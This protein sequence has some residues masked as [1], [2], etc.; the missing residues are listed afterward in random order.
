M[1]RIHFITLFP[2]FCAPYFATS[3]LG[4]AVEEKLIEVHYHNPI[5]KVTQGKRV[6]ARPYGG[7]PGMVL[8][9]EPLLACFSEA[10]RGAENPSVVFLTPGGEQ[11]SQK[12]ARHYS[13]SDTLILFCGHYEGIDER[14]A[15]AT[16]AERISI[17]PF[18]VTGGEAPAVL[19]AD[20]VVREIPLVLGNSTSKEEIRTASSKVYTRPESLTFEGKEYTVPP[21]LLSGAH[22]AIDEYRRN[23]R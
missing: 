3:I 5:E 14:V 11:F 7:G 8:R 2:E 18:T 13:A 4:R 19:I 21:V 17:G 15:Q 10:V 12:K 1:F 9:P 16:G 22:E 23:G 6:D 20:A